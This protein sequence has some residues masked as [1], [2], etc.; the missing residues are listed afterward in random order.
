MVW[1][2]ILNNVKSEENTFLYMFKAKTYWH[3]NHLYDTL[4]GTLQRV[5]WELGLTSIFHPIK[6][7]LSAH[8]CIL[9]ERCA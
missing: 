8:Y 1:L 3:R 4:R 7:H 6:I 2:Y 9:P 5:L